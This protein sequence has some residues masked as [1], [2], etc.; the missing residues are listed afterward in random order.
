LF[1]CFFVKVGNEAKEMS[2]GLLEGSGTWEGG[3]RRLEAVGGI[4]L[5][6][7]AECGVSVFGYLEMLSRIRSFTACVLL[8]ME[9]IRT[10]LPGL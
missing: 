10:L 3:R 2:G 5:Q 8:M 6:V 1:V 7:S 4:V 9:V